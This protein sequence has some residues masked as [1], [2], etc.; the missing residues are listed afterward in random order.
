MAPLKLGV[1]E[2]RSVEFGPEL[3]QNALLA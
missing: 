2:Q 3:A 1:A